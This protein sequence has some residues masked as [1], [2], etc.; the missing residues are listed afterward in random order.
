MSYSIISQSDW[1]LSVY[2]EFG[3]LELISDFSDGSI[4]EI[5]EWDCSWS[6]ERNIQNSN[7][8]FWIISA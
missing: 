7:M 1:A 4:S 5:F 6:L 2:I 8:L 3:N